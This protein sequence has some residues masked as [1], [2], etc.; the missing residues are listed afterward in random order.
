MNTLHVVKPV[1]FAI[2][3]MFLS[4]WSPAAASDE[5]ANVS[6]DLRKRADFRFIGAEVGDELGV[7]ARFAD[8]NGDG[9]D[10]VILG[11]WLADG[12]QNERPRSG[13]VYVFFG[14]PVERE[15]GE[16]TG[17]SVIYGGRPGDRIGSSIDTG[18]F[19]GDGV[20]D[21]LVGARYANGPADSL[22]HRGGEV[23]LVL[24]NSD[25]GVQEEVDLRDA[26]DI[27]FY[28]EEPGDRLGRRIVVDDLDGDGRDDLLLAAV[29]ADGEHD[30]ERDAGAVYIV[31]GDSKDNFY[32]EYDLLEEEFPVM[33]GFDESDGLG[34]AMTTGDWNGDD[35]PD[36]VFGCGFADGPANGRTNAGETYV[37]FGRSGQ[38][39]EGKRTIAEGGEL[40]IYG[41]DEYD[42]AGVSVALGDIDG[43]GIDDLAI[44]AN[45]ADGPGNQRDKCGEVYVLFGKRS[46]R[47]DHAIDLTY[48]AEMT[49]FGAL[50]GDQLGSV[51]DLYDWNNDSYA[52]LFLA[53]LMNDGPGGGR[54]DAGMIYLLLGS[55]QGNLR[56]RVD[57]GEGGGDL[58]MLGPSRND[59]IATSIAHGLLGGERLVFAATMLGDGPNDERHDSGEIY[60]LRWESMGGE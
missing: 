36:I 16:E 26:A 57:L 8:L 43:D 47:T 50:P 37:I 31:Y 53:S 30:E 27:V 41:A 38:R 39:F 54:E 14:R 49:V 55:R 4:F 9:F 22:R 58:S 3:W 20:P 15:Q 34:T 2:G 23:F 44:G 60:L 18:D 25:G 48:S 7:Q 32:R 46:I 59:K 45:L 51:T 40:T 28:G 52:D 13:E 21:L 19:D 12:R 33:H 5:Q 56:P 11:A 17:L 35:I 29:G 1:L 10:E 6:M 42:A 24:G